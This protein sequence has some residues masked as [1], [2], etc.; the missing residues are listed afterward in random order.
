MDFDVRSA[1]IL[2]LAGWLLAGSAQASPPTHYLRIV[3]DDSR[4]II[5][6][7]LAP[8]GIRA[9]EPLE[10]AYPLVGGRDGQAT[11][12]VPAG[13]CLRD[14]RIIYRDSTTLTVTAWN[15]CRQAVIHIGAA[16][17]ADLRQHPPI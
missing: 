11:A 2:G 12:A 14:L 3:N 13:P 17:Q 6:I 16:R 7:E 8:A 15:T 4:T 10:A 9:F 1:R 5:R